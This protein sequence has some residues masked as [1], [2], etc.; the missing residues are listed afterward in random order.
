MTQAEIDKALNAAPWRVGKLFVSPWI[1]LTDLAVTSESQDD[2][3]ERRSSNLLRASGGAGLRAYLPLGRRATVAGHVLPEYTWFEGDSD[4]GRLNGRFGLGVFANF[5][6][7]LMELSAARHDQLEF[8]SREFEEQVSLRAD[9]AKAD[10]ELGLRG[11]ISLFLTG[12]LRE[13]RSLED[14]ASFA[15]LSQ[16]DRDETSVGL[17]IRLRSQRGLVISLGAAEVDSELQNPLSSGKDSDGRH[18]SLEIDQTLERFDISLG[19]GLVDI[20]FGDGS[21]ELEEIVG[22]FGLRRQL[23]ERVAVDVFTRRHPTLALAEQTPYFLEEASGLG[24]S[25]RLGARVT[26]RLFAESGTNDYVG[27]SEQVVRSDDFDSYGLSLM[28]NVWRLTFSL[29]ARTTEY[30]SNVPGLDRELDTIVGGVSLGLGGDGIF[31]L[32]RGASGWV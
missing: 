3:D 18:Y 23:G 9:T 22:R 4:R 25:A 20:E 21:T 11:S 26:A 16:L 5:G 29:T 13:L 12:R 10:F 27:E 8:F 6:G 32:G 28:F 1:G 24:V 15:A 30:D 7:L 2:G 19:L 14:S 17:G 31:S